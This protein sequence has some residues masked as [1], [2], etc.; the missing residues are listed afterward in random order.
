MAI[1]SLRI[2]SSA[3][4][5]D[6][7]II[8]WYLHFDSCLRTAKSFNIVGRK[9]RLSFESRASEEGVKER[10]RS[11]VCALPH[12]RHGRTLPKRES[13]R[14]LAKCKNINFRLTFVPQKRPSLKDLS[15]DILSHFSHVQNYLESADKKWNVSFWILHD[16]KEI[17]T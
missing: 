14:G 6:W 8:E 2:I 4:F 17:E 12:G 7:T 11:L 1:N 16:M 3:F 9:K 13:A 5:R 10:G 15:H